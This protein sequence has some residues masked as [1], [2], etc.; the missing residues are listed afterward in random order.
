MFFFILIVLCNVFF[1]TYW[2]IK[3][4]Q[5]VHQMFIKKFSKL[6][7]CFCLCGNKRKYEDIL[8]IALINEE[9]EILREGYMDTLAELKHLYNSGELI[10]NKKVLEKVRFYLKKDKVLA[11]AGVDPH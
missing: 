2:T 10:L 11:A 3:L 5:E 6:Y 1:F 4:V 7:T 8:Q 9:N